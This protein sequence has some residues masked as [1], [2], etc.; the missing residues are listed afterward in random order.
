MAMAKDEGLNG[1]SGE[2][3]YSSTECLTFNISLH[4]TDQVL[5]MRANLD[6]YLFNVVA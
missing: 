3:K 1:H 6:R 5:Q 2:Y 4:L